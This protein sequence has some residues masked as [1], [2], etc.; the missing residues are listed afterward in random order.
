MSKMTLV[1]IHNEL[2]AIAKDP[3]AGADKFRALKMLASMSSNTNAIPEPLHEQE[4]VAR[5]VRVM[6]PAGM[7]LCQIAYKRAFQG[8]K[9]TLSSLPVKA[10]D[11]DL[12]EEELGKV[13]RTLKQFYRR[14]P[15]LKSSGF[16]SGYPVGRSVELKRAWLREQTIKVITDRK[17]ETLRDL[18]KE[19]K[20]A[21]EINIDDE[22]AAEMGA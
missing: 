15:E 5:L 18:N 12:S 14:F 16:P 22:R 6:R 3:D 13:P 11:H 21:V 10:K 9:G 7:G 2:E 1:D 17:N 4:I 8:G 20:D 19:L